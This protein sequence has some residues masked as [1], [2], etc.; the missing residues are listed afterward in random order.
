MNRILGG[1]CALL[2]PA[3][4]LGALLAGVSPA[5]AQNGFDILT[6]RG[7]GSSIGV[8][9]TELDTEKAKSSSVDHGVV[10]A[11]VR[12]ETPA[13][14]AGFQSGDIVVE[15]DGEAVR[16]A[17]QFRRLVEETR[18]GHEVKATV[19][20]DRSRRSLSVTPELVAAGR[21][22]EVLKL[23]ALRQVQPNLKPAVP[24]R[25]E[26]AVPGVTPF[27]GQTRLGVSVMTLDTQLAEYFGARQGVLVTGVAADTPASRAGV[28]AGDVILEV[29]TRPVS[30]PAD[31]ADALR[32][33]KAGASLDMKVLRDKKE[34]LLK[35]AIPAAESPQPERQRL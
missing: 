8:E 25:V 1:R 12:P 21:A 10:V 16:S 31:V 23:P 19:V 27:G 32:T 20:R 18:P 15:F 6:L 24:F 13:A 5:L 34:L 14:R 4:V 7:Q 28:R 22:P 9:I 17:R 35:L 30:N 11:T 33:V 29:A 26:P 2:A 3:W